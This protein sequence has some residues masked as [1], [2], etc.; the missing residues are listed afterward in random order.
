[1][2]KIKA[3]DVLKA[4]H[5][6]K[7]VDH[8]TFDD[9]HQ[10]RSASHTQSLI[11][12]GLHPIEIRPHIVLA[13]GSCPPRSRSSAA[14][15]DALQ[16]VLPAAEAEASPLAWRR[17]S[18]S[19]PESLAGPNAGYSF[20]AAKASLMQLRPGASGVGA[21]RDGSI[22]TSTNASRPRPC[23]SPCRHESP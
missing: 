7:S 14:H 1:M 21:G 4:K 9:I 19:L 11:P 17:S 13:R 2:A 16:V 12:N 8:D 6:L 22:T 20:S 15:R 18:S 23:T 10:L 5:E 3:Q